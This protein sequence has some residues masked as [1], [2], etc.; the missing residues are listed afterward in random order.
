MSGVESDAAVDWVERN[1]SAW[2]AWRQTIWN[3]AEPAWRDALTFLDLLVHPAELDAAGAEFLERT[4]GAR[5][6]APLLPGYFE[7][8]IH[9]PW[10]RAAA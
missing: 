4:G 10:P 7:P 6:I 9:L 1:R 2:S 3:F 8:P 5:H